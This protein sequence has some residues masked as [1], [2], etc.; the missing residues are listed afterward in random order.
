MDTSVDGYQ[1]QQNGGKQTFWSWHEFP[2]RIC[3]SGNGH[4]M[5]TSR[6]S[7]IENPQEIISKGGEERKRKA[8]DRCLCADSVPS[9]VHWVCTKTV[10]ACQVPAYCDGTV[11][12]DAS[13]LI[14]L[15]TRKPKLRSNPFRYL[16][17][18]GML[19]ERNQSSFYFVFVWDMVSLLS[20][21]A[22]CRPGW[23]WTR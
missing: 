7:E 22:W 1:W 8:P 6:I 11:C 4:L 17:D 13:A 18:S 19:W 9:S 12:L 20:P 5:A 10:S 2:L 16:H 21:A 3:L 15:Y 14:S 23:P